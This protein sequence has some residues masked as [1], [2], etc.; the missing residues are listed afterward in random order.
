MS[1]YTKEGTYMQAIPDYTRVSVPK[2]F[3][4]EL[5]DKKCFFRTECEEEAPR[6]NHQGDAVPRHMS[7][8]VDNLARGLRQYDSFSA[9]SRTQTGQRSFYNITAIG[10]LD[11]KAP[12][13][14]YAIF[15]TGQLDDYM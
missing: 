2:Q 14:P 11:D 10:M 13:A 8:T 3:A 12:P 9:A 15:A 7:Y 1:D 6:S 4:V 5:E